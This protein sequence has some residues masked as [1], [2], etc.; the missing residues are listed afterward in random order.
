MPDVCGSIL[1]INGLKFLGVAGNIATSEIMCLNIV[2][3]SDYVDY[4]PL[5][6]PAATLF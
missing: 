4:H 3:S 5:M 6:W 2:F 1:Y